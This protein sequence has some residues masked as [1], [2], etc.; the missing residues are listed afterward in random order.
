MLPGLGRQQ[1]TNQAELGMDD[2]GVFVKHLLDLRKSYEAK[3]YAMVEA[4]KLG[5]SSGTAPHLVD[6]KALGDGRHEITQW[7]LG[8][9]ASYTPMPA[10]GFTVNAG[11]MKSLFDD[12]GIDL[13]NAMYIDDNQEATNPAAAPDGAKAVDG[14]RARRL[15]L[16]L[17][18]L[19][20]ME[21]A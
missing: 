16:E 12:A 2:E 15:S 17:E 18:L 5:W 8:L 9:D 20:L 21:T 6:R 3:L 14:E 13:L 19:T 7:T 1:L 11:A 10:G 4:G